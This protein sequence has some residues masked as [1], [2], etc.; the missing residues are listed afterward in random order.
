MGTVKSDKAM[1]ELIFSIIEVL[2][3]DG[4]LQVHSNFSWLYNEIVEDIDVFIIEDCVNDYKTGILDHPGCIVINDKILDK[5][6]QTME[7][8]ED[9]H[10]VNHEEIDNFINTNFKSMTFGIDGDS[11][12]DLKYLCFDSIGRFEAFKSY[13]ESLMMY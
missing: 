6:K 4:E 2:L 8:L 10:D 7:Y 12:H 9:I 5:I 3:F 1:R 11:V 13:A